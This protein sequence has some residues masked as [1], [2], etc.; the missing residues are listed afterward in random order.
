MAYAKVS[1]LPLFLLATL[2]LMFSIRKIEADTC[3][4]Y[5]EL[6]GLKCGGDCECVP[7]R[8]PYPCIPPHVASKIVDQHPHICESHEDCTRKGSGS[9][10]GIYPVSDMKYGWCFDSKSDAEASFKNLL[11][12]K[13]SNLLKMPSA[14]S[15]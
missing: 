7:I 6:E 11:S 10:C 5:C 13:F 14:V 4:A 2:V 12:S 9:F 15:T 3:N 1:L 8:I